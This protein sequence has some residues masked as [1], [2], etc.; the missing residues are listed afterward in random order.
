MHQNE[1]EK[2]KLTSP[3]TWMKCGKNVEKK[4]IKRGNKTK[5]NKNN[6]GKQKRMHTI[7][8]PCM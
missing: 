1:N 3:A 5:Q 4:T 8:T 6:E 7:M 2:K